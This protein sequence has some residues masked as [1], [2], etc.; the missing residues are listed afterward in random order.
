MQPLDSPDGDAAIVATMRARPLL[1]F[2]FDGTLAPIVPRPEDAV[3][4]PA[5][6]CPLQ[7]LARML[8]V[9]IVTGRSVDDV[10]PRL[11]FEPRFIVG[12]HGAEDPER[13]L[14]APGP[15]AL[16]PL[17]GR[18]RAH[19]AELRRAGVS[20]EDKRL[21]IALHYR[22]APDRDLAQALITS[23]VRRPSDRTRIFGGKCVV[24]VAPAGAPDKADAVE[25]LVRQCAAAG[26]VFVGD[27]DNDEAVFERAP[28]HWLTV[29]VGRD[30][31]RTRARFY[32][33]A[34]TQV[35]VLLQH[36]LACL[37]AH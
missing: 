29:R 27:D 1:A 3:A 36:M 19:A 8:P 37:T 25:G 12:N 20:V 4:P 2:D 9:A 16:A 34:P 13:P 5:I 21:S 35:S 6:A 32:V 24:N 23:I 33:E 31:R 14:A 28:P 22:L 11:G 26:A 7:R 17:R 15:Y 18:L 10:A 30:H